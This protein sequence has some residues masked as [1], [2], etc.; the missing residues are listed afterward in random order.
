MQYVYRAGSVA[1]PADKIHRAHVQKDL[2]LV[3]AK[4][5]LL[6]SMARK[7]IQKA[8]GRDEVDEMMKQVRKM[9][10]ELDKMTQG[11]NIRIET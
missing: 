6:R 11:V 4:N 9:L 1:F 10:E 5:P 7:I 8:E 2:E 3:A